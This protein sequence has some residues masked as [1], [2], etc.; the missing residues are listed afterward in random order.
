M[1]NESKYIIDM[2][3]HYRYQDTS[4]STYAHQFRVF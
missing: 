1:Y 3:G 2:S 4:T